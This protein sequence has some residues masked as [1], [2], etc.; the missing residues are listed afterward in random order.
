MYVKKPNAPFLAPRFTN[1][2]TSTQSFMSCG[3]GRASGSMR[4]VIRMR[5]SA[6]RQ[7]E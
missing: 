6:V 5:A 1:R 2:M 3:D 4:K 7:C